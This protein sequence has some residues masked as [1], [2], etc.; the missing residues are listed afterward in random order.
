MRNIGIL[1]L[2]FFLVM[3]TSCGGS[4][5]SSAPVV[6]ASARPLLVVDPGT[7]YQT[8][9]GWEATAYAG[10]DSPN[11]A[12]YK[13]AVFDAVIN[14]LGI[15]RVRLEVR[16]GAENIEDFWTQQKNGT[17]SYKTWR[18]RRYSTINDNDDPNVINSAGFQWSDL[19]DVVN[20]IVMP[21][22]NRVEANG[23]TLW[24]N[25][26]YVA[27]TDQI[28]SDGTAGLKYLHDD[29]DEYA[30]FVEAT[31][32]HLFSTYGWVPDSW[33]IL[34]EPD[35]VSQWN[36]T[37]IGNAI[38]AAAARLQKHGYTPRFVAPSNTNMGN[39]ITYFDQL[40]AVPGAINHVM[41]FSYHRYG[42]V[43]DAN[44]Q[45]INIRAQS[46][47]IQTSHL[48]WI[49]ATHNELHKDLSIAQNSS[50][51]QFAIA[52]TGT[53]ANDTG[54]AYYLADVTN[55]GNPTLITGSRTKFLR[56]YFKYVRRGA[57]RIDVGSS[58]GFDPL[59]FQNTDGRM[60]V[61]VKAS[62]GGG[63]TISGLTAGTYGIKY[64]T[65][66]EYDVDLPDVQ[67]IGG[68]ALTTTIPDAGVI[69]IHAR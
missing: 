27:F 31:Y 50:W 65:N 44:L 14:D 62:S 15:N 9:N 16:A 60:V 61:V 18:S 49:G 51:A 8:M 48:E 1:S 21:L 63:F 45:A 25:L 19:D 11:F 22:K 4:G 13:D 67:I 47:G 38:V 52:D 36:G 66:V 32:L 68:Q 56:Q 23:E 20:R 30:E 39:A 58:T 12:D 7:T 33:E 28:G 64:S 57:V 53:V 37:T 10:Q 34:L 26:C 17:I 43:S 69:T 54:G 29:P 42:G 35:N 41:E 40:L 24:I 5:D 59:A 46:A 55:P 3:V 6:G 2:L